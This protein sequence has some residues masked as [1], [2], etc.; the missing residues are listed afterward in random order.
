MSLPKTANLEH[1]R[2][3]AQVDFEISETDMAALRDL[4]AQD[5]GDSSAFPVYSGK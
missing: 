3:N 2:S 4:H 5:Y 1:M